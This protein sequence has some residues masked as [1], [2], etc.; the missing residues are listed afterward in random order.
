M[1]K[2]ETEWL[3]KGVH[4]EWWKKEIQVYYL[5]TTSGIMITLVDEW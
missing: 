2:K 5:L 4:F 1:E 3:L